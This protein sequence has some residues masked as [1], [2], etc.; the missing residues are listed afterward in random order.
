[1]QEQ[2]E[3]TAPNPDTDSVRQLAGA[4]ENEVDLVD[5]LEIIVRQRW[6]IFLATLLVT[7]GASTPAFFQED[8]VSYSTEVNVLLEQGPSITGGE[9]SKIDKGL[10]KSYSVTKHVLASRMPIPGSND[11]INVSDYLAGGSLRKASAAL[12]GKTYLEVEPPGFIVI[13]VSDS[14][15]EVTSHLA[16]AY[17]MALRKYLTEGKAREI[18]GELTYIDQRLKEVD[19][20]VQEAEDSLYA[21]KRIHLGGLDDN[22]R[23]EVQREYG[24]RQRSVSAWA[25][26][27]NTLLSHQE[28]T[29]LKAQRGNHHIEVLSSTTSGNVQRRGWPI[30]EAGV[31][32]GM[33]MAL[34]L[35]VAFVRDYAQRLGR[36]GGFERLRKAYTG[37]E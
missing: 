18:A 32:A 37:E 9:A 22:E 35:F 17:V 28:A 12:L 27:Y 30:R 1:M 24:I 5:Y 4:Y 16:N 14:N 20:T 15:A 7:V 31:G 33:G 6:T 34:G 36:K 13:Q 8:S 19:R 23:F 25:R 26:L 11:S 10:I 29:R 3:R 21:F 2:P